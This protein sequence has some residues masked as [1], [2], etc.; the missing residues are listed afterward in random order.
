MMFV[1]IMVD[2]VLLDSDIVDKIV[3]RAWSRK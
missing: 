1:Y 3:L 2:S